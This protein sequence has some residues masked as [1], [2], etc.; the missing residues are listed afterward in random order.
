MSIF[1]STIGSSYS[2]TRPLRISYTIAEFSQAAIIRVRTISVYLDKEGVLRM[3]SLTQSG[4]LE[5]FTSPFSRRVTGNPFVL[6]MSFDCVRTS[7]YIF[8]LFSFNLLKSIFLYMLQESCSKA[9]PRKTSRTLYSVFPLT[10]WVF[11]SN[12]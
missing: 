12:I 6:I 2:S 1:L 4:F 11:L 3:S 8:R 5:I 9:P 10:V 7:I